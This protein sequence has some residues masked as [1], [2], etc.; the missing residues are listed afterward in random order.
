MC[1]SWPLGTRSSRSPPDAAASSSKK[2]TMHMMVTFKWLVSTVNSGRVW[3]GFG[4][5][6]V[7][8]F[9]SFKLTSPTIIRVH[10]WAV[11]QC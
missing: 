10:P 1:R 11:A 5:L 3:P 6:T 8:D 7:G 9:M 2:T 4:Y